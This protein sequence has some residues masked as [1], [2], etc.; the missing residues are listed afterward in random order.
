M[1]GTKA[2]KCALDRLALRVKTDQYLVFASHQCEDLPHNLKTEA[3][4]RFS[5]RNG[6][7]GD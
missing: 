6:P 5:G 2:G 3:S 4:R 7:R 1:E